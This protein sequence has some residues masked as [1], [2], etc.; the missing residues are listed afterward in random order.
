VAK[1]AIRNDRR[2][3][4]NTNSHTYTI[5]DVDSDTHS[6]T[7][8]Y[9]NTNTDADNECDPKSYANSDVHADTVPHRKRNIYTKAYTDTKAPT[10]ATP[11]PDTAALTRK[12]SMITNK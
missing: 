3:K 1:T 4:P 9:T 6:Y 7:H 2:A 10:S 8:Y 12:R 11:S 5:S